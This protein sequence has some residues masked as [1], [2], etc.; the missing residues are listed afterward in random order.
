M[1]KRSD[2]IFVFAVLALAAA[3]ASIVQLGGIGTPIYSEFALLL[4]LGAGGLCYFVAKDAGAF[5]VKD[6]ER[7]LAYV[8][9]ALAGAFA[10]SGI[11]LGSA[12]VL[13]QTI[14]AVIV[15]ACAGPLIALAVRSRSAKQKGGIAEA[16][17]VGKVAD[18]AGQEKAAAI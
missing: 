4:M 10:F 17:A 12:T 8:G 2:G 13:L 15:I 14:A 5:G 7:A 11:L 6:E 9:I 3:G 1:A 16:A 18:A